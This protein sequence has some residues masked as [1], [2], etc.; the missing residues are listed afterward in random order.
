[1]DEGKP[2]VLHKVMPTNSI[3]T[4]SQI[5]ESAPLYCTASGKLI[6]ANMSENSI[7]KYLEYTK[8]IPSSTFT[9]TTIEELLKN[10]EEIRKH[11]YSYEN[12]ELAEGIS[13]PIYDKNSFVF[14]AISATG[15]SPNVIRN[16]EAIVADLKRASNNI[17]KETFR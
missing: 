10:L 2:M 11:G 4:I 1:M 12:Q 13:V 7:N 9:I 5:W 16:F 14:G 15:A 8:L 6:L 17:A 3:Y